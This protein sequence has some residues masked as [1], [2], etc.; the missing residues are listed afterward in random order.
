MIVFCY[1]VFHVSIWRTQ[2]ITFHEVSSKFQIVLLFKNITS[3]FLLSNN[4]QQT[5][6]NL[7]LHNINVFSLQQ[8]QNASS[9]CEKENQLSEANNLSESD[10]SLYTLQ[11]LLNLSLYLAS[12]CIFLIILN[13]LPSMYDGFEHSILQQSTSSSV[14]Y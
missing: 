10:V 8:T 6:K 2:I 7:H 5:T 4:Y 14:C 13:S 1:I 9:I 12:I 11:S 3:P